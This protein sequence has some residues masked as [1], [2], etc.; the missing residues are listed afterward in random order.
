MILVRGRKL[1]SKKVTSEKIEAKILGK[2]WKNIMQF[3][4]ICFFLKPPYHWLGKGE[5][6]LPIQQ[7]TFSDARLL[8]NAD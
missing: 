5:V 7:N 1:D 8:T 4:S 2:I 6:Q 3:T